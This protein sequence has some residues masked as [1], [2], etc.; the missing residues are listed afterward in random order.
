MP[1]SAAACVLSPCGTNKKNVSRLEAKSAEMEGVRQ[2]VKEKEAK[3]T[4]MSERVGVQARETA[5][6]AARREEEADAREREKGEL[7]AALELRTVQAGAARDMV[8][9]MT[10]DARRLGE[11]SDM[12]KREAEEARKSLGKH[13]AEIE[14]L[15]GQ[16]EAQRAETVAVREKARLDA[17][18]ADQR[19]RGTL[20][21]ARAGGEAAAREQLR[22]ERARFV[23]EIAEADRDLRAKDDGLALMREELELQAKKTQEENR[24]LLTSQKEAAERTLQELSTLSRKEAQEA[25]EALKNHTAEIARLQVHLEAQR[26]ETEAARE[27]ATRD[28]AEAGRR[29]QEELTTALAE[30]EAAAQEKMR[31]QQQRLVA[32]AAEADRELRANCESLVV[33]R[34]AMESQAKQAEENNRRMLTSQQEAA[35]ERLREI[36]EMH[37]KE[38]EEAR[39]R[40]DLQ[41]REAARLA[42]ERIAASFRERE[43]EVEEERQRVARENRELLQGQAEDKERELGK[44]LGVRDGEVATLKGQLRALGRYD[45]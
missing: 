1:G 35:E 14:H 16:L 7:Q 4:S 37:E 38:A 34:E 29:L 42:E 12:S 28:A 3:I 45:V 6:A 11:A 13:N 41:H 39:E 32:E 8:V 5:A 30:G 25:R 20:V 24:H 19:L 43:A 2:Q 31:Q 40:L 26:A 21:E 27:N 22:Q 33:A 17:A 18:E 23:E 36:L 10:E 44:V 15:R 9:R